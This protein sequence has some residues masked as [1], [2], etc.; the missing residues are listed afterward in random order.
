MKAILFKILK[1][2]AHV[3]I[4]TIVLLFGNW[5]FS[6]LPNEFQKVNLVTGLTN[7]VT[8]EFSPDGRVF[9][10]DRYGEILI[11]NTN[12]QTTTSAGS[13]PVFHENE[14]GLLG[15]AFDP[16][17][18]VNNY[19]YLYYSPEG[20]LAVNRVSRYT[21][22]GDDIDLGSEIVLL[23]WPTSRTAR[24][25]SAGDM[26][27]DSKGNL[28]IATGD[29]ATYGNKYAPLN[30]VNPD[31][32]AEKASSNTNDLR[33]KILR[34]T[35]QPDGTYTIPAGNLFEATALT[36]AEIYVM[37]ARNPFRIFV[38]K[39]NTDWLF[40]GEVGPDADLES[41]LG[42][43]GLD[44]INLV[45]SA[46]NYGWPY[47]S[48]TDNDA[49]QITYDN[50]PS[51]N[52]PA[53]PRNISTWNTGLTNL[54]EARPALLE[55]FHKSYFSGPRYY[56][57]ADVW[58]R[59]EQAFPVE[60]DGIYFYYD[61]NTSRIWTLSLDADGNILDDEPF[62]PAIFPS[63]K[64]GFID[65]SFGP[66]GKMYILAYGV[67]CCGQNNEG[68]G[69]LIRVDYT[70]ITT[71][72]PPMVM[73]GSDTNNGTLPLTVNFSSE[74]TTDPNGD[75]PLT[76][77]WDF[78]G[79]G[80]TDS[81]EENPTF[82]YENTGN[83]NAQLRVDDGNGGIGVN[84]LTIY[85]GNSLA[86]FTFNSPPDGG[87][88]DWN[89]DVNVDVT[90]TD[91][92]DGNIDCGDVGLVPALGHVNH[93]HNGLTQTACPA[94]MTLDPAAHGSDQEIFYVLTAN[95]TD[96]GGLTSFGQIS[97]Y[98][99][100]REAEFYDTESGTSIIDN[101]DILEGGL[102]AV[103]VDNNGFISFSGRNLLNMTGVKYKVS[104]AN[105][106]G[107]IELRVGS[108]TGTLV[109]TTEV[110]ATGGANSWQSVTSNISP[111]SG[112]NDLF[113]VFKST[114]GGQGIF[115]I[116]YIEFIGAGVSSDSTPPLVNEVEVEDTG[117]VL[118]QFSEYISA[119]TAEEIS[120]YSIDN[121]VAISSATL[122]SDGRTVSLETTALTSGV[123]Y[124]LSVSGVENLAGL[125]VV[126]GSYT[127]STFGATRIN[128][129][130]DE[131]S[132]SGNTTF[133]ADDHFSSGSIFVN[134]PVISGTDDET[135]Y[136]SERY[137]TFTYDIPAPEPGDYDIRLHFAEIFFGV[138]TNTGGVGSR[139]FD[140]SIEGVT[141]LDNFD[142]L[143]ETQ[144]ATALIKEFRDVAVNDGFATISFTAVTNSPKVS[145]IELLRPGTL[146]SDAN[147]KILSPSEGWDVNQPFEVSFSVENWAIGEMGSGM[148]HVHYTVDNDQNT[149]APHYSYDPIV[150]DN[151]SLGMHTIRV[152]LYNAN[153]TPTGIFDE[154]MVN[155]T[156]Q[157]V[158]NDTDFPDQW[159]VR[160]LEDET[161]QLAWRS[162]Y[163]LPHDD[164]D[165]DGLKDI[166]TGA[167]WYKNPG[168]ASGDWIKNT[169]GAPFNNVAYVYDFDNDGD[170]DLLGTQGDYE[171]SDMAWAENDGTGN[172]TVRLNIPSGDEDYSE[173]FLAGIA[174][175][176]FTNNGL[177]QM[178]INWNGA[179]NTGNIKVQL[180][181]VPADPVNTQWSF[182]N[183]G[184]DSA[185]E[186]IRSGDIDGDGDL[187]LFQGVNWLRN[188]GNGTWTEFD[189]GISY[190]TT[191]DRSQLAD[192]DGDGRLD[193]VVGQLSLGS[194]SPARLEF[195]W[196]KA[197][198]DPT[199][200]WERNVLAT[201]ING[202]LSVFAVD[203]DMDGDQD[204]I[205]GEWKGSNR[206]IA[207][208]N[209]LCASGT[210]IKQELD[211]GGNGIDHHDSAQVTDI[212]NDGDLDVVSVG[213]D[214][215]IARIY[216][217][218]TVIDTQDGIAPVLETLGLQIYNLASE[219]NLQIVAT[220]SNIDDTLMFMASGL[221][222][223]LSIDMASG[224]I[225]GT[226]TAIAGEY[227]VEVVVTDS[228]NLTDTTSFTMVVGEFSTLLRINA[229]G[230]LVAFN[231][232]NWIADEFFENGATFN[233]TTAIANT[234]N[235]AIFQ[236]E[237]NSGSGSSNAELVYN[238]PVPQNGV[239][240]IRLYFS[241]IFHTTNGARIFDVDIENGQGQLVNYD[242]FAKAGANTATSESFVV[243][244]QDELL[245]LVFSNIIDRAKI[246]AIE[247]LGDSSNSEPVVDAGDDQQLLLPNTSTTITGVAY[248]PDGGIVQY[249]WEQL[250][251]PEQATL[252]NIDEAQLSVNDLI[253]G[254]YNF[255][256]TVTDDEG[257]TNSDEVLVEV[258]EP[259]SDVVN[260]NAGDPHLFLGIRNGVLINTL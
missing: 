258:I 243:D 29:N 142:I 123:P 168:T 232:E 148:T 98:P 245:T 139:V 30:E 1:G 171:G 21:M 185:G 70:G 32:S 78:D 34:I 135:L 84:N 102:E 179:E 193:A 87:L 241:E 222:D 231:A 36:R 228:S 39:Q 47:F 58:D 147:I 11:Y 94:T 44:E 183:I 132:A 54:P 105:T 51:Y 56:F 234:L 96:S 141:V 221:P 165:G 124:A 240:G 174:P 128:A 83:F 69:R 18:S 100:R 137:G 73:I 224:A 129:G 89:D 85:A 26:A 247:L 12:T 207:F 169:I 25:H 210:W 201:D 48:G 16:N 62:S 189:T 119:A 250:A 38:D 27:F 7:S 72:S 55:F 49:Y 92:Q 90:T 186:D 6:Q 219:V 75:A 152:E 215:R 208:E 42:P 216:E 64:D 151:L 204:I 82:I 178:A 138:G 109:S 140:V 77:A 184:P 220:D 15:I 164:L 248:D 176:P 199:Q 196:F 117:N 229:G 67:G 91:A 159:Q 182:V 206:L 198:S 68:S 242:I 160:Y 212:D 238:I 86:Q 162:V 108:P 155:V 99:K 23:E 223:G 53:S 260:I 103:R 4:F 166:V 10:L 161:T 157:Q 66:D 31:F 122:L 144:P 114:M 203:M 97:L 2:T 80:I 43:E 118:V 101:T 237:R 133:T 110:P 13:I 50:P 5:V 158:C 24:W 104:S 252:L 192:F 211:A 95:F 213:W 74:G 22:N 257:Q 197:P 134:S 209:D 45:K 156:D 8:M 33:G 46:G 200:P 230:P 115:D 191:P 126:S 235:D 145:A 218:T 175:G 256:L 112:K 249:L 177:H 111:P 52:D 59:D 106:G 188:E 217:N 225:T 253:D 3:L 63:N 28:Y 239:Y 107:T 130:G 79:D 76:Y 146:P 226:L 236:T 136:Q 254:T 17:F 180:L 251:G 60:F 173:P 255:R 61:F 244:V 81:T 187:D 14:D 233:S 205:V 150:F 143:S 167:W 246:T 120:N 202:S 9:L 194:S 227:E 57:D 88:V 259:V 93:F 40:W 71:N 131:Y 19:V 172:F 41:A 170:M 190:I 163:I 65:M 127:F 195:S 35:P 181:T 149:L 20:N 113:F 154:V 121:A 125:S 116:N 153:H 37:G 214:N